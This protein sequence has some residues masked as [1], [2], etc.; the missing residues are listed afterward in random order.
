MVPREGGRAQLRAHGCWRS[1]RPFR[2]TDAG[3]VVLCTDRVQG[4]APCLAPARD[5]AS[6][7]VDC[8]ES[9]KKKK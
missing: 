9:E 8:G 3:D 5:A 4:L 6:L 1:T 7:A 2:E